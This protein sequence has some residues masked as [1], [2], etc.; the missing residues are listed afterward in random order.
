MRVTMINWPTRVATLLVLLFMAAGPFAALATEAVRENFEQL[1]E[2]TAANRPATQ[3]GTGWTQT[4]VTWTVQEPTAVTLPAQLGTAERGVVSIDLQR[5]GEAAPADR[6]TVFE[7]KDATGENLF[8]FQVQWESEVVPGVPQFWLRGGWFQTNGMGLWNPDVYGD[9]PIAVG[10]WVHL[11]LTWDDHARTYGLYLDGKPLNTEARYFDPGAGAFEP[12]DVRERS[13][14]LATARGEPPMFR[15]RPFSELAGQVAAV[16]LGVHTVPGMPGQGSSPLSNAVLDNFVIV[17]DEP[18]VPVTR[19]HEPR[20]DVRQL[21]GVLA[22]EGVRLT[23]QPPEVRGVNQG[24]LVYQRAAGDGRFER[25]TAER[26]YDLTYT[27]S[28]A[29]PGKT[30]LY[31]VT[32]VYAAPNAQDIE[33][34]YPPEI[35]VDTGAFTVAAEKPLYGAGQE[36]VVTLR[37]AKDATAAFTVAGVTTRPVAMQE[38]DDGVYVGR[39]VVPAGL[40]LPAAALTGTLTDPA[41]G[42]VVTTAGGTLVIDSVGPGA[43]PRILATVPW[44]GEIE[45]AWTASPAADVAEYRVYRGEDADPVT[46]GD[47]YETT[48]ELSFTDTTLVPGIEYRYAVVPVDAAGNAGTRSDIVTATAVAGDGP[49]VSA[50]TLEPFGRPARPGAVLTV[51]LTGQSGGA[52]TLDLGE[53]ASGIALTEAGRTGVYTATYT[54]PETA[55]A[56]T[57]TSHRLVAHLS[58]AFG[59]T[60]QAGPE[61]VIVGLDALNDHTAPVIAGASHDAFQV[62]GFSGKLVAGDLL[63]VSLTGEPFG[64][65]SFAIDG[66]TDGVEM[67]ETPAGSGT[68]TGTYTVG[69]DDAGEAAALTATLADEGGNAATTAVGRPL[70]FDTRVRL[71]VTARDT[72]LPADRESQ[73]RLVVKAE[74]ANGGK[75]SGHELSLMLSTT[76]EYTGVVGGGDVEGQRASKDDADDLEVKWGGTTDFSGEVAATYTAGFAAKTALIVVK[77]LTTGDVG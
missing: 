62:A 65:A 42:A 63:S 4:A 48:A 34:K 44:A 31:S 1:R 3:E 66:V 28:T 37:G 51:T 41:S 26:V 13:N 52:A 40:N 9:E 76:E 59:A 18:V 33:S 74:D 56:A 8:R 16:Q 53:L 38:I 24:Y 67:A 73:T 50:I 58:D 2:G 14:Q 6:R 5:K 12:G 25:L 11:D 47:A 7:L 77:D 27:D 32:A 64:Y 23:W 45:L 30:Y 71:S 43:V 60:D 69:W 49:T 17:V 57:K 61:L 36:I 15:S 68:Y 10:Q 22:P 19:A 72:L 35:T 21:A 46:T 39:T 70:V 54:V 75:V 29:E 55:V 20:Y